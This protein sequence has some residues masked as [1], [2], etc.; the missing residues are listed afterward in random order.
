ME[1]FNPSPIKEP[2]GGSPEKKSGFERAKE[3]AGKFLKRVRQVSIVLILASITNHQVTHRDQIKSINVEG[4]EIFKHPD[5]ETTHILNYIAGLD[6]L[7]NEEQLK[8]IKEYIKSVGFIKVPDNFDKMTREQVDSVMLY[9]VHDKRKNTGDS[10][11]KL[12][13]IVTKITEENFPKKY[14]YNDT[15][16][17]RL[18]EVEQEVGSPKI[19]WTFGNKR[20][21]LSV[22]KEHRVSHYN[23]REHTLFIEARGNRGKREQINHLIAEWAH[24]KQFHDNPFDSRLKSIYDGMR[25]AKNILKSEDMDYVGSQLKEYH[26]IGSVE[27]EAH[28]VIEPYIENK[29]KDIKSLDDVLEKE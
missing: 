19:K 10:I 18:W 4:K 3:K 28:Q 25:I 5:E 27:H 26:T 16:Y 14:E 24:A 20:D 17:K 7:S 22:A 13:L 21:F 15:I 11:E 12:K 6:S 29:F 2:E 9:S 8:F 23:P 1:K